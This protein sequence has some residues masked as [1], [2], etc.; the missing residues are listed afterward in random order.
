MTDYAK[1]LKTL[2]KEIKEEGKSACEKDGILRKAEINE[3][4]GR[5]V[6]QHLKNEGLIEIIDYEKITLTPKG[7][8]EAEE[9][10]REE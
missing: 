3:I 7:E 10:L 2:Y 1:I 5:Q 6:I 8:K 4:N 9:L